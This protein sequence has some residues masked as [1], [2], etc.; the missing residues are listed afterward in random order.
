M[1]NIVISGANEGIGFHM[2]K[3][4]LEAGHRVAVLDIALDGASVLAETHPGSCLCIEADVRDFAALERA[5]AEA[6]SSFG[7]ID[8][9]VQNACLCPFESF[10]DSTDEIYLSAYYVNFLGAVHLARAAL[11]HM[12]EGGRIAFTSSGVGVTGFPLAER[13]CLHE[14]RH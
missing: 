7:G 6:A 12:N 13:L 10:A 1:S 8:A 2:A 4:L 11:P 14:R 5:V 9:A 3:A